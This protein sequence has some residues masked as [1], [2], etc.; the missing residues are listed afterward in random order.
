MS[1]VCIPSPYASVL[2]TD[3]RNQDTPPEILRRRLYE[4][5]RITAESIIGDEMLEQQ[6]VTTPM[7]ENYNGHCASS[8]RTVIFSTRDDYEYFARGV[9]S[10]FPDPLI[11]YMDF[12]GLRGP[13]ALS[14]PVRAI[15]FPAV[16]PGQIV[17]NVIIA[18]SI[19]A[20]GCTA[21]SL[22]K[23]AISKYFPKKL[24]IATVFYSQ[25]GIEDLYAEI[26]NIHKIY[27]TGEPDELNSDGLLLPGVGNLDQRLSLEN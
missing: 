26:P 5:G 21:I 15:Q 25:H 14:K 19:L 22:A 11:G 16:K 7:G 12:A 1:V 13:D 6:S 18:K 8:A 9:A 17:E 10:T 23:T 2:T 24:I 3:I 20:T 4:L 27:T